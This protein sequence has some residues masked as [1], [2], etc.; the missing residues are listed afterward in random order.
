M[1]DNM[2]HIA[3]IIYVV[4]SISFI[5]LALYKEVSLDVFFILSA[6]LFFSVLQCYLYLNDKV[7]YLGALNV[8]KS[9]TGL[10]KFIF[11]TS[12]I[13]IALILFSILSQ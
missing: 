4:L 7:M 5:L 1:K 10:R 8:E 9:S 2:K 11:L 3:L 12:N 13:A 6:I